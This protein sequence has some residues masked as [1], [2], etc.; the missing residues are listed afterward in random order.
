MVL[1]HIQKSSDQ[2]IVFYCKHLIQI[3]L[4]IWEDLISNTFYSSTVCNRIS[5]V[6]GYR[7]AVFQCCRHACRG[8]RFHTDYLD[9]RIQH[10][11]KCRYSGH[12][13]ASADRHQ[14]VVYRRQFLYDLHCDGSL[15]RGHVQV[16]KRMDKGTAFFFR[17][18]QCVGTCIIIN[19]AVQNH[20][21]AVALC[22][23]DFDKRRN[24]RHNNSSLT[25]KLLG[26]K[27]HALGMVSCRSSH[28][29]FCPFFLGERTDLIVGS[30]HLISACILHVLWFQINLAP[31][32]CAQVFAEYQLRRCSYL[33]YQFTCPLKFFQCKHTLVLL[34][35]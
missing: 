19:I 15:S 13:T 12:Q 28:Q 25:S 3:L 27:S 33:F 5:A 18:F 9:L 8:C 22:A 2:F 7:T 34:F 23:V 17:Q 35:F 16:I 30:P 21:S 20:V 31:G 24:C 26:G 14:D 11:G 10:F 4:H 29:T 32:L 6:Q 1:N